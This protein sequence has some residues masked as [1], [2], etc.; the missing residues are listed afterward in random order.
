MLLILG[1][2]PLSQTWEA[3]VPG[4]QALGTY[5]S[6]NILRTPLRELQGLSGVQRALV[7]GEGGGLLCGPVRGQL[8]L[9]SG[10]SLTPLLHMGS[11]RKLPR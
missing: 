2:S 3:R 10:T 7:R 8:L 11:C 1:F 9:L 5:W 6:R 4:P